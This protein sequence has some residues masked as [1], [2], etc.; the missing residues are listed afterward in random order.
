MQTAATIITLCAGCAI[1]HAQCENTPSFILPDASD[2][3]RVHESGP[4]PAPPYTYD[5][6]PA[7]YLS[8][9]PDRR[10]GIWYSVYTGDQDCEE[11]LGANPKGHTFEWLNAHWDNASPSPLALLGVKQRLD[12]FVDAG[13]RRIN[14]NRPGG[15]LTGQQF[16]PQAHYHHLTDAQKDLIENDLSAWIDDVET[17]IDADFE[18]GV[19]IGSWQSG[20]PATPC[21][22]GGEGGNRWS[23]FDD[24]DD[25]GFTYR[26]SGSVNAADNYFDPTS[27]S[28]MQETFQ[29]FTPWLDIG[30]T[31][32]WLDNSAD[33]NHTASTGYHGRDRTIDLIQSPD[34][35]G[36]RFAGEGIPHSENG[37][38]DIPDTD[39]LEA[40]PWMATETFANARGWRDTSSSIT[41]NPNTTEAIIIF[42]SD[43][44]ATTLAQMA[45]MRDR[46]FVVWVKAQSMNSTLSASSVRRI[47]WLQRLYPQ[48]TPYF[49]G[50]IA[51]FNGDGTVDCNDW[52][53]FEENWNTSSPTLIKSIW[54]GDIDGDG[55]ADMDDYTAF[56]MLEDW[57]GMGC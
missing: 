17:N 50:D 44:G 19:F 47:N 53:L 33:N 32:L 27:L 37:T 26:S 23:C 56:E 54:D 1:A 15:G 11:P 29:N 20:H 24:D 57:S 30:C 36:V 49:S 25:L 38:E 3:Y 6:F 40:M 34:Y 21:V 14:I 12:S 8:F 2:A 52:Y 7:E 5:P 13:F 4:A 10:P 41:V 48:L 31:A 16:V 42:D 51:D 35:A 39:Y 46:G 28:S 9:T 18:F 22:T 45:G 55:D 43:N